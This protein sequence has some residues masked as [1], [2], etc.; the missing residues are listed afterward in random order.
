MILQFVILGLVFG[1]IL[2]AIWDWFQRDDDLD[3]GQDLTRTADCL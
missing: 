2:F 3:D 1:I